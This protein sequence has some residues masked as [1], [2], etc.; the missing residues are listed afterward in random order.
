M[1]VC[2]ALI[3]NRVSIDIGRDTPFWNQCFCIPS[4][5][6]RLTFDA[7][8]ASEIRW[9]ASGDNIR[10]LTCL[11]TNALYSRDA[12]SAHVLSSWQLAQRYWVL[13]SASGP[14]FHFGTIWSRCRDVRHV[15]HRQQ[16]PEG[17]RALPF[18]AN[19]VVLNE[20]GPSCCSP[21]FAVDEEQQL[22]GLLVVSLDAQSERVVPDE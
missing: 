3:F 4:V 15:P 10:V 9:R 17:A 20:N 7:V 11:L 12:R 1:P 2:A 14:P 13:S 19:D 22:L 6:T 16:F 5:C 8:T 18:R 21:S